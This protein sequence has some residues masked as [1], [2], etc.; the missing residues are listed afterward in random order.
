MATTTPIIQYDEEGSGES[1]S[2]VNTKI[3]YK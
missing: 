1:P 3:Q 2:P